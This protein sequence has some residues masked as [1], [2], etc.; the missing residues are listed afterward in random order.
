MNFFVT[1]NTNLEYVPLVKPD[2][3]GYDHRLL[4]VQTHKEWSEEVDGSRGSVTVTAYPVAGKSEPS[5]WSFHAEGNQGESV[6][7]TELFRVD[8]FPCCASAFRRTYFSVRNGHKL[9]VTS[10]RQTGPDTSLIEVSHDNNGHY[11]GAHFVAFGE[12]GPASDAL[13]LQLGT[14]T[15]LMQQLRIKGVEI[16]TDEDLP[17]LKL[18]TK[19]GKSSM[20]QRLFLTGDDFDFLIQ[21][22]LSDAERPDAKRTYSRKLTIPV[23]HG[24]M[25]LKKAKT[26][27][28]ISLQASSKL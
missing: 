28:G 24:I 5:L 21:L 2:G 26:P 3:N 8:I 23:E 10:S 4:A 9:Y 20:N 25:N 27:A 7:Q 6:P 19:D 17:R 18:L 16:N 13:L 1:D 15:E 22:S 14:D 12:D 11:D